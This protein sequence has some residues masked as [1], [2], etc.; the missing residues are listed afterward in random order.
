MERVAKRFLLHSSRE[1][2]EVKE[3]DFDEL[4]QNVQMAKNELLNDVK[5]MRE[6]MN[7]YAGIIHRGLTILGEKYIQGSG[8]E[9]NVTALDRINAFKSF[10]RMKR[11]SGLGLQI[12]PLS[13]EP[14]EREDM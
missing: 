9:L 14:D 10:E 3:S 11:Q 7:R 12:P 4:K 6:N 13:E 2:E 5:I 1:F 8:G